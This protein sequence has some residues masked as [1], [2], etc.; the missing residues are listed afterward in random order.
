MFKSLY[1]SFKT[2]K[3]KLSLFWRNKSYVITLEQFTKKTSLRN[4]LIVFN[5]NFVMPK[6]TGNF[7][8]SF[9]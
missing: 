9:I 4:K 7:G 6:L 3:P 2:N 8:A 5:L 1:Q